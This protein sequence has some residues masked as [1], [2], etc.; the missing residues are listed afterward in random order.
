MVAQYSETHECPLLKAEVKS[1]LLRG[2]QIKSQL[3]VIWP[4][5]MFFHTSSFLVEIYWSFFLPAL[6]ETLYQNET[7]I[8]QTSWNR[9]RGMGKFSK[10]LRPCS[11]AMNCWCPLPRLILWIYCSVAWFKNL[12][13][14]ARI[15]LCDQTHGLLKCNVLTGLD[16]SSSISFEWSI[17]PWL[18]GT[19]QLRL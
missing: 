11:V 5:N 10:F 13:K 17:L 7:R 15:S 2:K 14:H 1:L 12:L 19:I 8:C 18:I 16:F 9:K 3:A 6:R 4:W